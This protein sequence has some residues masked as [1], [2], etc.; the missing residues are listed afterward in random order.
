[1]Q[2]RD[3][4]RG[5]LLTFHGSGQIVVYFVLRVSDF[6][7]GVKDLVKRTEEVMLEFLSKCGVQ[8][9]TH[10]EYP[11]IWVKEKKMASIGFRVTQDVTTHGICM[12]LC[13]DLS[14]YKYFEPC[15][16][17]GNVMTNLEEV[18]NRKIEREEFERLSLE[19]GEAFV[20]ST[21]KFG[22]DSSLLGA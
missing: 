7:S 14:V 11:G 2:I 18:L 17:P 21:Q 13:N 22:F 10:P 9:R 3:V 19:L 1:M 20:D 12:N 6:F 8:A 16:L 4:D 15:G 5:G